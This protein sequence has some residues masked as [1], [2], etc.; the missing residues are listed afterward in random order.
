MDE[1][2]AI[3]VTNIYPV[4]NRGILGQRSVFLILIASI[5]FKTVILYRLYGHHSQ[6]TVNLYIALFLGQLVLLS[7]I[8]I[9]IASRWNSRIEI[10]HERLRQIRWADRVHFDQA[11]T[12]IIE[13]SAGQ[14]PVG[15]IVIP[16]EGKKLVLDSNTESL[17]DLISEIESRTGKTFQPKQDG[18]R[19]KSSQTP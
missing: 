15:M 5:L 16:A 19:G 1:T 18:Q 10:S 17:Q 7:F 9:D 12:E 14:F 6:A 2:T 4:R 11:W 8:V 3:E 13:L